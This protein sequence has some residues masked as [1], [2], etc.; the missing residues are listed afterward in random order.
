MNFRRA[1]PVLV[2]WLAAAISWVGLSQEKYQLSLAN[3]DR[4][5]GAVLSRSSEAVVLEADYF[6]QVVIPV[7]D[8]RSE[9]RIEPEPEPEAAPQPE[10][11]AERQPEPAGI[12]DVQGL[13]P[14]PRDRSSYARLLDVLG[15]P[16][17][18][19][20]VE[21]GLTAQ[22]GR[23]DKNDFSFRYDM[24]KREE[25]DSLRFEA[26][27]YYGK[28]N[29]EVSTDKL[30]SNFRYRRDF[31]PGVF[32]ETDTR[33]NKDGIKEID[34]NLEQKVGLGY[35]FFDD[36]TFKLSTG[37]GASGRLRDDRQRDNEVSYLLDLF[38]D[39]DYRFSERMRLTQDMRLAVP[40]EDT[41]Q[42]EFVFRTSM[43]SELTESLNLT[44]RYELEYDRSLIDANREDRRF[45]SA[46]GYT[47]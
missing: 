44:V 38:Q 28:T 36:K 23:K 40:L 42:Y 14:E 27:Y 47:F 17:W 24:R 31:V 11:V 6:G 8:I 25:D 7:K 34:L 18:K 46:L 20:R 19:K 3:G 1:R 39:I 26:K 22:S 45:V 29:D 9:S 2:A 21:F 35:R 32:Y 13:P 37:A 5:T 10:E 15:F 33:Y 4:I 30:S 43:V 41:E 16:G 12:P